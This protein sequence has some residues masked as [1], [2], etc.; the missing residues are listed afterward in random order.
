MKPRFKYLPH[1]ADIEFIA[2]GKNL[3]ETIETSALA[4]LSAIIDQ[5]KLNKVKAREKSILISEKADTV[6]NLVWF[7][8][9]DIISK[10]DELDLNAFR[11]SVS[12]LENKEGK[13]KLAGRLFYKDAK[14]DYTLL[15]IKAVTPHDLR[16]SKTKKG[17]S[18]NIVA[19]V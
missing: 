14:P 5:K 8:L 2:Y 15:D 3:E 18:I 4:M 9:Q 13:F 17:Y 10:R 19:D 11:F 16:V 7:T 12:K 6:E 1:T